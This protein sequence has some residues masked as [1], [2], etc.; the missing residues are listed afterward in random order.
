M[1]WSERAN[2][3]QSENPADMQCYAFSIFK[4]GVMT[5]DRPRLSVSPLTPISLSNCL[6]LDLPRSLSSSLSLSLPGTGTRDAL[7]PSLHKPGNCSLLPR[8]CP[9]CCD[10][11]FAF[12]VA[13]ISVLTSTCTFTCASVGGEGSACDVSVRCEKYAGKLARLRFGS[14]GS[15][16]R[17][18]RDA[19]SSSETG[20]FRCALECE[21]DFA[22]MCKAGARL[23]VSAGAGMRLKLRGSAEIGG[24]RDDSFTDTET[25]VDSCCAE[26]SGGR[27]NMFSA[28]PSSAATPSTSLTSTSLSYSNTLATSDVVDVEEEVVRGFGSIRG[29]ISGMYVAA[30][31][32]VRNGEANTLDERERGARVVFELDALSADSHRPLQ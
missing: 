6:P 7:L 24:R 31:P 17:R 19:E 8:W 12:G 14:V 25:G 10:A 4:R 13:N 26:S 3:S 16:T 23:R 15:D 11:V 9:Q 32:G 2:R 21:W 1:G 30:A 18:E 27:W 28:L 22:Y 20:V 5:L 29:G